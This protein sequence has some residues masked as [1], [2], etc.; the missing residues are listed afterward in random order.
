MSAKMNFEAKQTQRWLILS[1]L[2]GLLLI[3]PEPRRAVA[4][5]DEVRLKVYSSPLHQ[6][7]I[8]PMLCGNFMELLDDLVPGMWAEMLGGPRYRRPPADLDLGLFPGAAQSLRPGL[9]S[10]PRLEL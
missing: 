2:A 4:Q 5:N 10:K 8:S 1:V 7:R 6:G 9:G 3:M